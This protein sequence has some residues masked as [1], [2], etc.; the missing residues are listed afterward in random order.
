MFSGVGNW[1]FRAMR[2]WDIDMI[3]GRQLTKIQI[4]SRSENFK[5]LYLTDIKP[6][7]EYTDVVWDN[8]TLT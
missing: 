5:K 3:T 2:F 6:L 8:V 1:T 7:F 4:H